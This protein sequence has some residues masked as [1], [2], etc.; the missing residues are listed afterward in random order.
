MESLI[1]YVQDEYIDQKNFMFFYNSLI[2]L[3]IKNKCLIYLTQDILL[4]KSDFKKI[5][6]NQLQFK[7]NKLKIESKNLFKNNFYVRLF[8]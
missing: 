1:K 5:F 7:K 8:D 2:K 6:K 4:N 3:I